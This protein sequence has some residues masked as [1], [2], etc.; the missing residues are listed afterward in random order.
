MIRILYIFLCMLFLSQPVIADDKSDAEALVK[1]KLDAVFAVLQKGDLDQQAKKQEINAI[2]T[3]MFDFELMAKLT[4][5][6]KHW[7][8]LPREKREKFNELYIE[9]LKTSYLDKLA[10]YTDEKVIFEPPAQVKKKVHVPTQLV[11]KDRK[12]S[13]LYK[14]YKP[15][16]DWKVYDL[17]IQGVSIIRSYRSQFS[18]SLKNG[19]IDDL[20]LKMERPEKSAGS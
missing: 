12:T 15:G 2:V 10:L 18:E 5:G 17:E 13:I 1:S 19:T 4:L 9:M 3:P 8:G 16:D 20:L 14:L 11:S 6:K 7:P